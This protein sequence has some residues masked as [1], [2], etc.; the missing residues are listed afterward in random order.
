MVEVKDK[1]KLCSINLKYFKNKEGKLGQPLYDRYSFIEGV[2]KKSI[3]EEYHHFLAQPVKGFRSEIV[4]HSIPSKEI[5]RQ[6]SVLKDE[7]TLEYEKYVEIKNKTLSHYNSVIHSLKLKAKSD[8]AEYLQKAIK[9]MN[10]DRFIF[11]YDE[12][13]VAVA[14]GMEY[15]EEHK[16]QSGVAIID[17]FKEEPKIDTIY[18]EEAEVDTPVV[19]QSEPEK[20]KEPIKSPKKRSEPWYWNFNFKKF[21]KWLL[22]VLVIILL[23]FF[24]YKVY[25][26]I[27]PLLKSC[28]DDRGPQ[29]PVKEDEIVALPPSGGVLLPID[30][31]KIVRQPGLPVFVGNRLNILLE[32]EDKTIVQLIKD[33]KEKYPEEKYR[34]VYHDTIVRRMQI[35]F[36][37]EEREHL[38]NK[39]PEQFKPDY[40]LFVFD[41]TLFEGK[42]NPNDP[43]F[44]DNKK[45]WYLHAV[46]APQAWDITLGS[47][48]V[49]V[50]I[51]D[52]GFNLKHPELINKVVRP[53]NVWTH[54]SNIYPQK[55]DHGTLVAGIVLAEIDNEEGLSG[56]APNCS[57]IPV[58]VADTFDIMTITSVLDGILYALYYGADVINVSLGAQLNNLD[59][60]SEEIQHGL[61]Q[62][63]FKEEERLW[64]EVMKIAHKHNATIVIAAGN[65]NVLAGIDPIQR[66]NSFVVVSAVDKNNKNYGKADFSNYGSYSTISAPGID[67][68]NSI[69][70][71][72]YTKMDGTSVA[73]PIVTGGIALMKS[74]DGLLTTQRIIEILQETGA[75]TTG[76]IGKLI[77]L[78]KAL[79]MVIKENISYCDKIALQI[80]SLQHKIDSLKNL[81]TNNTL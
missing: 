34:V 75:S 46:K 25:S 67:I 29:V 21:L 9:Y 2:V 3:D 18:K 79:Q 4:M 53:F 58:Q 70:R 20:K 72:S 64:C 11:C 8:D 10:D 54:S 49:V 23:L 22:W 5:P 52:N 26:D 71:D 36:P 33:F 28:T 42:H 66:P 19:K 50:A 15:N 12:K 35:E 17:I 24:V 65:N 27:P 31:S 57:F 69:E 76:N 13:V 44:T 43:A 6:L 60:I 32:N 77:Q 30:T 38:K 39:I 73:A 45:S 51:V 68:Y 81:C 78:D 16:N 7:D 59:N 37:P 80:D 63:C 48:D 40:E 14:W 47:K 62:D 1:K 61:I 56:I 74:V 55:N 41:E